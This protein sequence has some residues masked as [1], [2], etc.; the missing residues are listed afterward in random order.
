LPCFTPEESDRIV[1]AVETDSPGGKRDYAMFR[2][3]LSTGLRGCDIIA[4]RLDGIDWLRD[5]I[6]LVQHKTRRPLTLPLSAEAGN[7]ITDWLLHGRP[8]CETAEVFV[9]LRAPFVR[10]TGSE[11]ANIMRRWLATA[12]VAH[13]A[14][15][16][17]TFH[18][19]RRTTGT[20][21]VESGAELALTAQVLGHAGPDSARPYIALADESLRVCCLP[22]GAFPTSK[23]GL[24]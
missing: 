20:R 3:A 19:L 9:R 5:E 23:E 11:G 18:A 24:R 2:L 13:E 15:D 6:R 8:V 1:A 22:L 4:L 16:G 21:L 14:H 12:G 17:K 7:A 10:L